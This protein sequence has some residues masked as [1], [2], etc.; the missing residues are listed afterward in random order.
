M[1]WIYIHQLSHVSRDAILASWDI[2]TKTNRLKQ[3]PVAINCSCGTANKPTAKHCVVCNRVL[4]YEGMFEIQVAKNKQQEETVK[5]KAQMEE[6]QRQMNIII[7]HMN[8]QDKKKEDLIPKH[9]RTIIWRNGHNMKRKGSKVSV[10]VYPEDIA[11][12]KPSKKGE[13]E[14]DE[15]FVKNMTNG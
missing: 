2:E 7:N 1:P 12:L 13:L 6:I 8:T 3:K 10:D 15:V 9:D 14:L 4:S 11:I 5:M